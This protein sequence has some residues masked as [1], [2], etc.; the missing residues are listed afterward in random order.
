MITRD[1]MVAMQHY[2]SN[3]WTV[4]VGE[5]IYTFIPKNNISMAWVKEEHVNQI[6]SVLTKSCCNKQQ[7]RFHLAS[8][9]NVNLWETGNRHGTV[10]TV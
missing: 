7:R 5:D 6:L 4:E 3:R 1:G 8:E 2:T 9:I 10:D